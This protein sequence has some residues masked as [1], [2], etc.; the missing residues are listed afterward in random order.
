MFIAFFL[1]WSSVAW[2][3][4]GVVSPNRKTLTKA[5]TYS[6]YKLAKTYRNFLLGSTNEIVKGNVPKHIFHSYLPI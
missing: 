5:F 1:P 2:V 4:N 6:V 3:G